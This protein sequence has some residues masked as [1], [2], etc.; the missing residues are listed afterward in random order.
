[1]DFPPGTTVAINLILID[2]GSG[3]IAE[4]S[5]IPEDQN[6][7][8]AC[9][10]KALPAFWERG[11]RPLTEQEYVDFCVRQQAKEQQRRVAQAAAQAAEQRR[12]DPAV[13]DAMIAAHK[14]RPGGDA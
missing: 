10:E 5:L 6:N 2:D 12:I 7:P 1:M 8:G 3:S 14:G 11:V 13:L 9:L 4:I